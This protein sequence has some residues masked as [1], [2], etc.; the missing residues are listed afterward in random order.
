MPNDV[1]DEVNE[2]KICLVDFRG[3][4]NQMNTQVSNQLLACFH[5]QVV[6]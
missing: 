3:H 5:A 4:L 2:T 6:L 1:N